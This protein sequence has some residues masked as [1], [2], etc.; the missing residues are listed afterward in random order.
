MYIEFEKVLKY[1]KS[2]AMNEEK[3]KNIL[4]M[5]DYIQKVESLVG[6]I[7]LN[8]D[9]K[10][11]LIRMLNSLL[12]LEEENGLFFRSAMEKYEYVRIV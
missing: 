1:N 11:M 7:Q 6:I 4:K 12:K 9:Q 3:Q 2:S 8:E 5:Q 10:I